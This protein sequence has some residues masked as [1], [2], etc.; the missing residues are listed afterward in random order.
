MP[1]ASATSPGVCAR[2][3]QTLRLLY[4]LSAAR[5]ESLNMS[6]QCENKKLTGIRVDRWEASVFKTLV[7]FSNKKTTS[8]QM[9]LH[10]NFPRLQCKHDHRVVRQTCGAC[11]W[12]VGRS[13]GSTAIRFE[14]GLYCQLAA[15]RDCSHTLRC[16]PPL[17]IYTDAWIK[18]WNS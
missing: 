9:R 8:V 7:Q 16:S 10:K 14:S 17:Q 15:E 12:P 3:I 1:T 6:V 13:P 2:G 4:I 18:S 11:A 5:T